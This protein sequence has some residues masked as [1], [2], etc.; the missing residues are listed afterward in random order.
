MGANL[1]SKNILTF[2]AMQR[3]E[4]HK[5]GM[6][7]DWEP[8]LSDR[9][10]KRPNG[11]NSDRLWLH[12]LLMEEA[13][14]EV[15]AYLKWATTHLPGWEPERVAGEIRRASDRLVVL[16]Q[17]HHEALSAWND[18]VKDRENFINLPEPGSREETI[19]HAFLFKREECHVMREN[20]W[21]MGD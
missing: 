4:R 17:E 12:V 11:D 21:P 18:I 8:A 9:P 1:M 5:N 16:M 19:Q 14:D 3:F 15:L 6:Q 2:K 7:H 13:R 20:A 10:P